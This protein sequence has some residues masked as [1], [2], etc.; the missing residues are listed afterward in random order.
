[1]KKYLCMILALCMLALLSGCGQKADPRVAE[2]IDELKDAWEEI[3]DDADM[4]SSYLEIKNIRIITLEEDAAEEWEGFDEIACIIEF[5]LLSDYFGEESIPMNV[6][7][8]DCV[9]VYEDGDMEVVSQHPLRRYTSSTF[10]V[11]YSDLVESVEDLGSAYDQVLD[12][13]K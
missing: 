8:M 4:D 2:A 9:V 11:D 6:D 7:Y 13:D 5:E 10:R 3:Y 12:L 1:M